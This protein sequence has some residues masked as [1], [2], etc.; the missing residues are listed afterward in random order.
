[1]KMEEEK[2]KRASTDNSLEQLHCRGEQRSGTVAG[3]ASRVKCMREITA[4]GEMTGMIHQGRETEDTREG[5][6]S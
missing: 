3:K 5:T 6:E 1:M 2:L 4:H